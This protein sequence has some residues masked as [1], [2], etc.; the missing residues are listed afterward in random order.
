M[1]NIEQYNCILNSAS[2]DNRKW[3]KNLKMLDGKET[4][5]EPQ[6]IHYIDGK[7]HGPDEFVQ[8]LNN[9]NCTV[10]VNECS[11]VF[12]ADLSFPTGSNSCLE[13]VSVVEVKLLLKKINTQ[14]V[15]HSENFP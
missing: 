8:H 5:T 11:E 14:Q 7:W 1:E 2:V 6:G 12:A 10:T 15:T 13:E 9:N 4:N 3:W